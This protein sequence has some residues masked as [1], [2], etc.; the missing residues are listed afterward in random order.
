MNRSN[1]YSNSYN[2]G[3]TGNRACNGTK[4]VI[5]KGDTLYSI[6]R[7]YDVPLA[8]VLRANPYVDVYN[9]QV[10]DEICIPSSKESMPPV[11]EPGP[12]RPP[13]VLGPGPVRPPVEEGPGPVMPPVEEGP[14]PVMPPIEEGPEPVMPPMQMG[15]GPVR[16]SIVTERPSGM[17]M[18]AA[19]VQNK[20]TEVGTRNTFNFNYYGGKPA[21][22]RDR[23]RARKEMPRRE[24]TPR[25]PAPT[26]TP[27]KPAVPERRT[28][29]VRKT[30][31]VV[32]RR[33]A[34]VAEQAP[35]RP[36]MPKMREAVPAR[37]VMPQMREAVPTRP[38]MPQ[39]RETV[40]VRR[41][42]PAAQPERVIPKHYMASMEECPMMKTKMV[43]PVRIITK[44][45]TEE[46]PCMESEKDRCGRWSSYQD[47]ERFHSIMNYEDDMNTSCCKKIPNCTESITRPES[48]KCCPRPMPCEDDD[49]MT[50][51]SYVSRDDDTLQDVLD[52]FTMNLADLF[53]YNVPDTIRLK[54]GCM[55]RVPGKGDD[56]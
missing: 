13:V 6:S 12:V 41:T 17:N 33:P 50:I 38:A 54:P 32:E 14:G 34:P 23:E 8:L 49:N 44:P 42:M 4:Y 52:Y 22:S 39:M 11:L 18:G 15:P 43:A 20:Q 29:Q 27:A 31:P 45:R 10:G 46:A 30:M 24:E 26:M 25:S 35:T 53:Q 21:P 47:R 2:S 40:P 7:R 51:I 3:K 37:P 5:K 56:K 55:I 16:P 19:P 28:T 1:N 36:V 9:L 48:N